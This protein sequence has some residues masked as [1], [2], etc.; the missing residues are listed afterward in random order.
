MTFPAF[1]RAFSQLKRALIRIRNCIGLTNVITSRVMMQT[2]PGAHTLLTS[3]LGAFHLTNYS[4]P[5]VDKL[6]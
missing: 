6:K 4:L 2:A 5:C 1:H 3:E